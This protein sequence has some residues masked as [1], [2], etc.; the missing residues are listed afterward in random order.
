MKPK[1]INMEGDM[2]LIPPSCPEG[3]CDGSGLIEDPDSRYRHLIRCPHVKD[4]WA[5]ELEEA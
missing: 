2:T 3:I 5:V 4:P 1:I